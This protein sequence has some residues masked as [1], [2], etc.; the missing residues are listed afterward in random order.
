MSPQDLG[1]V[2]NKLNLPHS[3]K[4]ISHWEGWENAAL[5][6]L[7]NGFMLVQT[8]DLIT[9]VVDDPYDFGQ[10]VAA[11]SI[12]DIYTMGCFPEL[13][14]NIAGFPCSKLPLE[15]LSTIFKGGQDKAREAGVEI[16][17][18]HTIEDEE[19]KFGMVVT[20]FNYQNTIWRVKGAKEGDALILT[21]PLGTGIISTAIKAGVASKKAVEAITKSMKKLNNLPVIIRD[22]KFQVH[23]CTD[24][25]GFGL[26]VHAH[27]LVKGSGLGIVIDQGRI[28]IFREAVDYLSEGLIPAGAYRNEKWGADK[29]EFN[30]K[31]YDPMILFDPQTS[32][33]LL[34]TVSQDEADD[35]LLLL[36]EKGFEEANIIGK[37]MKNQDEKIIII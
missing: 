2:L 4:V 11:N 5:Y 15:V 22:Y 16:V 18:G 23:S 20:G 25:T 19:L 3:P 7:P 27:S 13:A 37:F 24:V 12:S 9:P 33:G 26:I 29:V 30:N 34:I 1:E 32:G 10:I 21:K 31:D 28:P 8:V 6:Q 14:L 17:G 36:K 35:F